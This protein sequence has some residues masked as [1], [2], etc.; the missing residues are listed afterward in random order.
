MPGFPGQSTVGE[1]RSCKPMMHTKQ[2]KVCLVNPTQTWLFLFFVSTG[3]RLHLDYMHFKVVTC[4]MYHFRGAVE[5][6]CLSRTLS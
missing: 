1:L 4:F 5:N 3:H 6:L 2:K